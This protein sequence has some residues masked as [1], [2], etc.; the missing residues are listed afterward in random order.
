[1][2]LQGI[3]NVSPNG[4]F[5]DEVYGGDSE[6]FGVNPSSDKFR[7][8]NSDEWRSI[9]GSGPLRIRGDGG[10]GNIMSLQGI[11]NVSPNGVFG[12]EVYGGDSEGFG[13]NHSSDKFRLCN[14]DE[15]RSIN[16]SGPLRIHGDGGGGDM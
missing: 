8:C 2:S 9:N 16:G 15:W 7:L 3:H 12:D 1:M 4:V 5:G 14:S 13:V 10:G 11:H 6:G